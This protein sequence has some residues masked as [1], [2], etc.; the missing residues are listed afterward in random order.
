MAE[1]MSDASLDRYINELNTKGVTVIEVPH[2][3]IDDLYDPN[4]VDPMYNM[5]HFLRN[6]LEFTEADPE[7]IFVL[8][9]FA[10]MANPSSFHHP[11]P[12]IV[13]IAI[14]KQV[15]EPLFRRMFP[16]QY[17][18][19]WPDRFRITRSDVVPT[20]ES[21]HRDK[22]G[23]RPGETIFGGWVNLSLDKTQ[24][25]S[26]V[27]GTQLPNTA[28][29]A[30]GFEKFGAMEQAR[31]KLVK[32]EILVPPYHCIIF[33]E[34]LAHEVATRPKKAYDPR[35]TGYRLYLKYMLTP[36]GRSVITDNEITEY[37]FNQ[38]VP[39]I[40]ETQIPAM[41]SNMHVNQIKVNKRRLEDIA[42]RLKE[43]FKEEAEVKSGELKGTRYMR[44]KLNL[45]SLREAGLPLFYSYSDVEKSILRPTQL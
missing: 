4:G 42:G 44:P 6:Q 8:G 7:Q 14:T 40:S 5:D 37:T 29:H 25:F 22:S 2:I 16:G 41:Y 38:G 28:Q 15:A 24:K 23:S 27:P 3:Y 20:S 1:P 45:P 33:N 13:R 30:A 10:A 32:K 19:S 26:C 43:P 18:Q 17:M 11:V 12:R 31:L 35:E 21:F 39:R 36:T 34:T 9:G